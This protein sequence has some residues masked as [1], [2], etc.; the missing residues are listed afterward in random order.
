MASLTVEETGKI[1][2]DEYSTPE[3]PSSDNLFSAVQRLD[4]D[5]VK[6]EL[7]NG[8]DPLSINSDGDNVLSILSTYLLRTGKN[9]TKIMS[10]FSFFLNLPVYKDLNF[11]DS[12]RNIFQSAL[13]KLSY[14]F[15]INYKTVIPVM[16]LILKS[17]I[18]VNSLVFEVPKLLGLSLYACI[19]KMPTAVDL[20]GYL[21]IQAMYGIHKLFSNKSK[22][23][24]YHESSHEFYKIV[25][26][27]V[28]LEF[29]YSYLPANCPTPLTVLVLMDQSILRVKVMNLEIIEK[30]YLEAGELVEK[31][32]MYILCMKVTI[33]TSQL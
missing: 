30:I 26:V 4:L 8:C 21:I 20:Q 33:C 29:S 13:L 7:G 10:L 27:L 12:L 1:I 9:E 15:S 16:S 3:I 5:A 17:N 11:P 2:G 23:I 31:T 22:L 18:K 19:L 24:D 32:I 28:G 14:D 6:L 25:K